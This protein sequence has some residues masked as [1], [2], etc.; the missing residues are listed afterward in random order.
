M[1]SVVPLA[2]AIISF[3]FAI[4]VLDQYFARRKSYHLLWT[5]GLF[6]FVVATITE[7]WSESQGNSPTVYRLWYLSGVLMVSAYLGMGTLY[8]LVK[9]KFTHIILAVLV[10][11]TLYA[12]L[13]IFTSSISISSDQPLLGT[14]GLFPK[15]VAAMAGVFP[16]FGFITFVG[17]ALYS[18]W[19]FWRKRVLPYRVAANILIAIGG[20]LMALSGSSGHLGDSIPSGYVYQLL[21]I[22]VI[23]VGYMRSKQTFGLY[24]FPLIH[25]FARV[26]SRTDIK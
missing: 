5:I 8:L 18:T 4:L 3:V 1:H 25:G 6:I 9:R 16:T 21:G 23:F 26:A 15:D 2:S 17:G 19:M 20:I 22:V 24:R 7:F 10:I 12:I 13:R 11:L 14:T